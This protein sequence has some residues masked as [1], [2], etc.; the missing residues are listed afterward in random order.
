[1]NIRTPF[2]SFARLFFRLALVA[3][4]LGSCTSIVCAANVE[5]VAHRGGYIFAPENTCAAFRSCSGLVSQIEFDVRSSADGE[6]VLMHDDTVDRTTS[7][8]GAV[9]NLTLA[10]LK[11]L[12][13]GSKFLP[14]FAGERIPTFAEALRAMPPGISAMVHCKVSLPTAIL[15]TIRA[16]NAAT[17]VI[18]AADHLPFLYAVHA[19][20]PRM[21]LCTIGNGTLSSDALATMKSFGITSVS[22]EKTDV[23]SNLVSRVHSF[24]MRI[25]AWSI[26]TPE[27]EAYMNMGVDGL[28]VDDPFQAKTWTQH[29]PPTNVQ[30]SQDLVAYWK[31]DDGLSNAYATNADDVETRSPGRLYGFDAQPS[32]TSG[33]Q[34]RT[35]GALRLDGINDYVRIPTNEF[36]DIRTNAVSVSLWVNL[37]VLPSQLPSTQPYAGIYDSV[38]DAYVV[39]LDRV[40][41]ELRFKVTTASAKAARPGIPEAKLGTGVWHHIV[42]VYDGSAGTAIGQAL[43]FLDG[44]IVDVHSGDDYTGYGLTNV[45]KTGQAAAIGRNGTDASSCFAGLVDDVAIWRRPLSP[46]D[47]RQIYNA[48]TNG[49]PLE[50]KVMTL[51]ITNVYPDPETAD[52]QLDIRVEHGN[53]TNETLFLRGAA[54]ATDSYA[55]CALLP[56][57]RGKTA[58]FQILAPTLARNLASGDAPTAPAFFQ[59]VCP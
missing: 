11:A 59:V 36:L 26:S 53:L 14:L 50:K 5:I 33:D 37:S 30:L 27:I 45:V 57:S 21:N 43:I 52:M 48:G 49:I 55:D 44:Q 4:G 54:Q 39:Y 42:G 58:R 15:N 32:W 31:L 12:D 25:Y 8:T 35:G 10:Q 22:W 6:L 34:A 9:A 20:E 23:T 47:V 7:G 46:A 13:A 41:R 51:W 3:A 17:N 56:G 38:S 28:L 18:I 29:K 16:E 1:M 2:G 19:L 40:S 24:G